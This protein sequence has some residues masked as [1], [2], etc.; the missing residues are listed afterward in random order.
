MFIWIPS[1]LTSHLILCVPVTPNWSTRWQHMAFLNAESNTRPK[2][3]IY[4]ETVNRLSFFL[5]Y[6]ESVSVYII[7][8]WATLFVPINARL[9]DCA[10]CNCSTPPFP[11]PPNV[12][13]ITSPTDCSASGSPSLTT[14]SAGTPTPTSS[15]RTWSVLDLCT[16]APAAAKWVG[17][18][19]CENRDVGFCQEYRWS[20]QTCKRCMILLCDVLCFTKKVDYFDSV[21]ILMC[22]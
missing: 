9:A 4:W 7:W 11:R 1:F 10:P 12:P 17:P 19:H 3:C 14:G 22:L 18:Y 8:R 13:Q 20:V 21:P 15:L 6:S 2:C 5:Y 16:A